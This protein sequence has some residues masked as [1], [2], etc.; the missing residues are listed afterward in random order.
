[1]PE[2][3]EQSGVRTCARRSGQRETTLL[4]TQPD[5][6]EQPVTLAPETWTSLKELLKKHNYGFAMDD[7]S[8]LEARKLAEVL[9]SVMVELQQLHAAA[10]EVVELCEKRRGLS[11]RWRSK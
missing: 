7:L 3:N 9:R 10:G 4:P 6:G 11:V 2:V 5:L 1:A 8:A